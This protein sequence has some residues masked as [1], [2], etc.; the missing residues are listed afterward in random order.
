MRVL[1]HVPEPVNGSNISRPPVADPWKQ[2]VYHPHY[3]DS[4][5]V[6]YYDENTD[7]AGIEKHYYLQDA[8]FNVTAVTDDT[9]V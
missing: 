9:V 7:G 6:R 8:N 5:A 1:E 2:Y 3:V 4:I